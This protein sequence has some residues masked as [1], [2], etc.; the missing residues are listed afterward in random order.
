MFPWWGIPLFYPKLPADYN[1]PPTMFSLLNSIVNYDKEEDEQVKIKNLAEEGREEIF[2]F[3]YPLTEHI[4]K[5]EFE[6]MILNNYLMRRIGYDTLTAF[7]IALNVKLN[8]IMPLYNKMFDSLENWNLFNNGETI[9]RNVTRGETSSDSN[10]ST[11]T[12]TLSST[13]QDD[14]RYSDTPQGRLS[15]IENG[16]YMTDYTLNQN[17][18]SGNSSNTENSSG[19]K[20]SNGTE[21]ETINRTPHDKIEIYKKFQD[22]IKSIYQLIFDELDELFYNLV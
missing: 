5:E 22:E 20:T 3:E 12:S 11:N 21:S 16:T 17:T 4:T 1:L 18:S 9:T 7:K 8:S 13:S 10:T 19:N 15:D 2:D 6:I 14:T